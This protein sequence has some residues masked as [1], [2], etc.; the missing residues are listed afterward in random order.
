[1]RVN[2]MKWQERRCWDNMLLCAWRFIDAGL[3]V[4]DF[5]GLFGHAITVLVQGL[6]CC[7][8]ALWCACECL[9]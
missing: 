2:V 3:W 1:M 8:V 4:A 5:S 9:L 6:L 7:V